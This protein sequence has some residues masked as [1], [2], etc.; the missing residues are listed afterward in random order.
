MSRRTKNFFDIVAPVY[1]KFHFGA[2]RTFNKIKSAV[3]IKTS[4]RVVDLGGGTGRIA[5]FFAGKVSKVIVVD[6]SEEMINQCRKR[7]P[8]FSCVRAEAQNLPFADNSIDKVIIIDAFHHFQNQKLVVKEIKRVLHRN[9]KV[10]IEEFNPLT[11]FGKLVV[12]VEKFLLMH[13]VFHQP[14]SLADLFMRE[15]FKVDLIDE[16]KSSYYLIGEKGTSD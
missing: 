11:T 1:E 5:K 7:H 6:V 4:D 3:I 8:E 14:S 15:R 12:V 9:G 2:L 16:N 13:S 10:I